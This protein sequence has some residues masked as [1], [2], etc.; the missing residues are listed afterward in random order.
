LAITVVLL[1]IV[2]GLGVLVVK[3]LSDDDRR[4]KD[5]TDVPV[6][7]DSGG[8]VNTS[9]LA[10]VGVGGRG[11]VVEI[12]V[13]RTIA[14]EGKMQSLVGLVRTTDGREFACDGRTHGVGL[15]WGSGGTGRYTFVC[16]D[17]IVAPD[18]VSDF[19]VRD[20][21]SDR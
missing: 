2:I 14:G 18:D 21:F 13:G 8:A 12:E 17:S 19:V 10:T 4:P 6:V 15:N 5:R 1:A 3:V 16:G 7:N 11:L 9:G 20:Q